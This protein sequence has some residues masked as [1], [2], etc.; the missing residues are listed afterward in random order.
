MVIGP[1]PPG[2]GVIA[3][4]IWPPRRRRHRR[5]AGVLPPS[6]GDAV[7]ADIDHRGAGLDPVAAHHLGLADRGDQDVG[8]ARHRRQVAR[9]RMG[10][11]HGAMLG[12]QQRRHRLAD[13][14]GAADHHRLGA[15]ERAQA[16][17]QQHAGSHTACTA[18]APRRRS[19]SRPALLRVEAVDVL[20]RVDRVDDA[21]RVDLLRQRQLHQDAVDRGIGV[22]P[23]DQGEQL[24]LAGRRPAGGARSSRAPL[25]RVALPLLRT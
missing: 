20:G 12:E 16:R 25:P 4:A 15:G 7:D 18:P 24:G 8:A 21:L 2:T 11:R 14:V 3:P 5:R 23:R 6:P 10:D 17:A 19:T 9:A 22:E 13:D 1:T